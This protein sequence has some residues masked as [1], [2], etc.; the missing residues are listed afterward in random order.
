VGDT[1]DRSLA[2]VVA[3]LELDPGDDESL[4]A[5]LFQFD[6]GCC[7]FEVVFVLSPVFDI[8]RETR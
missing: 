8:P 4:L 2:D 3:D 7:V 6:V 1:D 5:L